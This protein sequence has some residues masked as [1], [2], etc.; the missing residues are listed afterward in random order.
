ME[1]EA[2][3]MKIKRIS[4]RLGITS[5]FDSIVSYGSGSKHFYNGVLIKDTREQWDRVIWPFG[6]YRKVSGT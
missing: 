5:I 3:Q 4:K 6:I 1:H 2:R